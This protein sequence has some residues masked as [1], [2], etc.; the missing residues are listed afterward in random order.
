MKGLNLWGIKIKGNASDLSPNTPP[1]KGAVALFNY[2]GVYH[3]ALVTDL[4][5][6]FFTVKEMNYEP[7]KKTVRKIKWNDPALRGFWSPGV[8]TFPALYPPF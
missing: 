5:Y 3:A 6:N 2:D 1:F 4:F 7:C 8:T